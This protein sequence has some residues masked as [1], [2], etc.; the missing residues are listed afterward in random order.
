[1]NPDHLLDLAD[2]I[3]RVEVGNPRQA[4]LKRAI[5][6]AYYALFHALSQMC[7]DRTVGSTFRSTR[8]W[9]IVTPIYRAMD[10]G[11]AKRLFERLA[12]AQDPPDRHPGRRYP[13]AHRWTS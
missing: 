6:T 2:K 8:Y 12:K 5:S 1:M 3:A 9:Q 13:P 10:H 4:S 11:S 7:V